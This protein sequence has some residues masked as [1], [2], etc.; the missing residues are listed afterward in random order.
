MILSISILP[1]QV[2]QRLAGEKFSLA[3]SSDLERARDTGLAITRH[4]PGL[5]LLTW[6]SLRERRFGLIEKSVEHGSRLLVC[7]MQVN[8]Q[9]SSYITRL[10]GLANQ[11][12]TFAPNVQRPDSIKLLFKSLQIY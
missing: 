2:G 11:Q 3:V 12:T 7:L 10:K 9:K 6:P 8:I 4:Q 1:D 5:E